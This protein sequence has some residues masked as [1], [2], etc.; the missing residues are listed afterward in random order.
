MRSAGDGEAVRALLRLPGRPDQVARARRWLSDKLGRSHPLHDDCVLLASE[1]MTNAVVHSRTGA[2]GCFTL[3]LTL[4]DK[5]VHVSVR[6][7]GSAL[8]PCARATAADEVSGRGLPM[9]DALARRW[10]LVREDGMN[11]VW[12]ELL[13]AP[14]G[15]GR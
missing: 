8:P 4:S 11:E 2:G 6:D 3:G 5:R 15:A 13:A 1:I 14:T 10:G 7:E 9:L 12:F